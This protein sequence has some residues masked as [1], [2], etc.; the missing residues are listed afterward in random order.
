MNRIILH[1]LGLLVLSL[2]AS[3][4]FSGCAP[5]DIDDPYYQDIDAGIDSAE[6]KMSAA[7]KKSRGD[8]EGRPEQLIGRPGR[9]IGAQGPVPAPAP[10][11][12]L[13]PGFVRDPD[14]VNPLPGTVVNTGEVRPAR[15]LIEHY[16]EIWQPQDNVRI[17]NIDQPYNEHHRFR[18]RI[19]NAPTTR[20]VVT[21]TGRTVFTQEVIPTETVN[22]PLADWGVSFAG[23]IGWGWGG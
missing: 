11:V 21:T 17:H 20:T 9:G 4:N 19:V 16:R 18:Q 2:G 22:L 23:C 12:E 8:R 7:D 14:V 6:D 1:L 15:R 3:I 10:V 5:Y 13:A